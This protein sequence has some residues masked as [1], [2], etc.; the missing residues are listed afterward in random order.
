M[1]LLKEDKAQGLALAQECISAH[2]PKVVIL[3]STLELAGAMALMLS[4]HTAKAARID[5]DSDIAHSHMAMDAVRTLVT[6]TLAKEAAHTGES[7]QAAGWD[8][9]NQALGW[10]GNLG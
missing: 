9:S 6:D 3:A 10:D 4:P 1:L 2:R 5:M 7:N 8:A